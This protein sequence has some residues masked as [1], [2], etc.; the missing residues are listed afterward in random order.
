MIWFSL[1]FITLIICV[2]LLFAQYMFYCNEN[3]VQMFEDPKYGERIG[4]LEGKVKDLEKK[5]K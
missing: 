3:S 4:V 2:T 5:I 1:I